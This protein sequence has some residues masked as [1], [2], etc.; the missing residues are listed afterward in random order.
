MANLRSINQALPAVASVLVCAP[1]KSLLAMADTISATT[2]QDRD[3]AKKNKCPVPSPEK[4]GLST[5]E[6][7][8]AGREKFSVIRRARS[9]D[10]L[11]LAP[12]R[13]VSVDG[14]HNS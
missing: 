1:E 11:A 13:V 8:D 5:M 12:Q 3:A 4:A 14:W 2:K 10:D 6:T 7:R 9:S